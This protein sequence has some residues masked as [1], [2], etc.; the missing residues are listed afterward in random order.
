MKLFCFGYGFSARALAPMLA[1]RGATIAATERRA[2]SLPDGVTAIAFDATGPLADNA[3][4][5][6][7]HIV[8][9]VPPDDAGDPVLR[10]AAAQIRDCSSLEWV[11]YLST[12]GVYGDRQGGWVDETG[13]LKP[14]GQRGE[15]RVLAENQWL[16][17]QAEIDAPVQIFRLAGIY[18]PG[19]NG[20]A[21]LRNGTARRVIKPGQV[22]SRIHVA[23]IAATLC[24]SIDRPRRGG[25]Y[26]V[27]D[28]TPAPPQDVVAFAAEL[29]GLPVPP[30][31][32]FADAD[33]SPMG[34]S[35]Y[36][37]SKRVSNDRIKTELGVTLSF[38]DYQTG[39]RAIRDDEAATDDN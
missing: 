15:R 8:S 10:H 31:I 34:R 39:L 6:V 26:N 38:P 24:A 2:G 20:F 1:A 9:S 30:G 37:E 11:A 36:G 32:P 23:D 22:F 13:D 28:D 14:A 19:R 7:T 17:L 21:A 12:T 4:D 27:C 35:F 16:D 29:L 18:G 3:L 5:G 33:L 25:I